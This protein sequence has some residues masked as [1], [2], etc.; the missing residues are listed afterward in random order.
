MI[1]VKT[2]SF[3]VTAAALE[4]EME[5][6]CDD[7]LSFWDELVLNGSPWKMEEKLVKIA[8]L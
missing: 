8:D 2:S 4:K 1:S 5:F 3:P 7:R 6:L